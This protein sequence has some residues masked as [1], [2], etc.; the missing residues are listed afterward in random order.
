MPFLAT[1]NVQIPTKD[2][3][4]WV[5]ERM[6]GE[7]RLIQEETDRNLVTLTGADLHFFFSVNLRPS[8]IYPTIGTSP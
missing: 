1:E 8:T 5:S 3:L 4:S 7:E 6:N 2:L